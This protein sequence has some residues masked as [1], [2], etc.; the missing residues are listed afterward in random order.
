[1][2]NISRVFYNNNR[3]NIQTHNSAGADLTSTEDITIL[4]GGSAIIPTGYIYDIDRTSIIKGRSSLAFHNNII[5]FEGLIDGDFIGNE[6]LVKLFN[7]SRTE[8]YHINKG[9]RI[10]QIVVINCHTKCHFKSLDIVRD[11][12]FGSTNNSES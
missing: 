12:G 5:A 9:D 2:I 4:P 10:A 7:L 11:G 1:M 8:I 6:I 3:P